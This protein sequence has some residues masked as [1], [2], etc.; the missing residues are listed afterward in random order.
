VTMA[1]GLSSGYLPISAT[2]VS[3]DI[4]Q[5]LREHG[6]EFSH[7]YTYSGHPAACAVA[8]ANID[9]LEREQLIE[10]TRQDTGPYLQ[11]ALASLQDHELVGETRSLGL[12]GAIEIVSKP[13][14]NERFTGKEGVAGPLVRDR[15]I[16]K[17]VM[18]RAIRDTLVCSPPLIISHAQIDQLVHTIRAALDESVEALRALPRSAEA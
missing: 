7:G 6:G 14:T 2:A 18:V 5:T 17:G 12:I 11:A 1:K 10:R 15:V 9:I 3:Q 4:V 8:L 13:H 16:A